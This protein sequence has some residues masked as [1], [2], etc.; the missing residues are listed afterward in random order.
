MRQV[1]TKEANT[2]SHRWVGNP[3]VGVGASD[4]LGGLPVVGA[5]TKQA[6]VP[7][8]AWACRG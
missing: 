1:R 8:S 6:S 2:E 4:L 3:G 7:S 5:G